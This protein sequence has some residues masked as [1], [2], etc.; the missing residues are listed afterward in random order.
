MNLP[1][2]YISRMKSLLKDEYDDYIKSFD[3]ERL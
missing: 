2:E 1:E 3:D